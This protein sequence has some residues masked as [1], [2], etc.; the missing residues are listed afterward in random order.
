MV[1]Q[2]YTIAQKLLRICCAAGE[3]SAPHVDCLIQFPQHPF[4]VVPA[5]PHLEIRYLEP[6]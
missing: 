6:R 5:V 1:T 3:F 2:T 4:E